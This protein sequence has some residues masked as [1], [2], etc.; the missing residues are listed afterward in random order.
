MPPPQ[1][2]LQLAAKSPHGLHWQ[3][4]GQALVEQGFELLLLPVQKPPFASTTLF[5]RVNACVP[6]PQLTEHASAV[7][8]LQVQLTGQLPLLQ[9]MLFTFWLVWHCVVVPG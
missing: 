9:V 5:E 8:E 2:R 4:T 6:P 1:D 3:S 7:Q